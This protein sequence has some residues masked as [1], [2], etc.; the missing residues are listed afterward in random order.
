MAA[1]LAIGFA[2]FIVTVATTVTT[3]EIGLRAIPPPRPPLGL[4]RLNLAL[5]GAAAAALAALTIAI[6]VWAAAFYALDVFAA[7][8]P[9]VYFAAVAFT[10]L[11]FGDVLLPMD[12]RLLSGLCAA[13]G[14][15]VFGL[16]TAFL[17]DFVTR[18]RRDAS[19]P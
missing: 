14:L 17:V 4:G 16:V 18:L 6:W 15:I 9:S 19:S 1:Q 12:W 11:G 10:T 5:A 7:V 8:E 13:N 3:L 2:A